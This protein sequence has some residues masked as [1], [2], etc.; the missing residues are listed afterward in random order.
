MI[1]GR[2]RGQDV[3]RELAGDMC[4]QGSRSVNRNPTGDQS[5]ARWE[6]KI[7]GNPG[8]ESSHRIV[9]PADF[10]LITSCFWAAESPRMGAG[11]G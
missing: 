5:S 7:T 8:D 11:V 10:Y 6:G 4:T 3:E 1:L 2:R 9:G